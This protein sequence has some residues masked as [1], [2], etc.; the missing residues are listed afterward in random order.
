[1]GT[2]VIAMYGQGKTRGQITELA[3]SAGTNQACAAI[4]PIDSSLAHRR[5]IKLYFQKAYEEIRSFSAGGAQP[6]LNLG[7]VANTVIPI[8][9]LAEQKRIVAKVGEL[10]DYCDRLRVT[11]RKAQ[12]IQ[13]QVA[14]TLTGSVS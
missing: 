1:M 3:I 10:L 12:S 14:D 2:L 7:K 4:Q 9:P 6:N 13:L 5:F 8:P 11:V